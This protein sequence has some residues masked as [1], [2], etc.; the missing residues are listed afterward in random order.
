MWSQ[1]EWRGDERVPLLR[2]LG[3]HQVQDG[4]LKMNLHQGLNW[5]VLWGP[6]S[7]I[8]K[9]PA[10][11]TLPPPL[12]SPP[13]RGPLPSPP[14]RHTPHPG[15]RGWTESRPQPPTAVAPGLALHC[16]LRLPRPGRA[17]PPRPPAAASPADASRCPPAPA[18][19]APPTQERKAGGSNLGG[20]SRISHPTGT[21]LLHIANCFL[22]HFLA[23]GGVSRAPPGTGPALGPG[24][25]P[26]PPQ[27][28]RAPPSSPAS[29]PPTRPQFS[30]SL[31]SGFHQVRLF[32]TV[33][34]KDEP[35]I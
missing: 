22:S 16:S 26:P 30:V 4:L 19:P 20:P 24:A 10:T 1:K 9:V 25:S 34:S 15:P 18:S 21:S 8:S 13:L 12:R 5:A 14:L 29:A 17:Y 23:G 35:L 7:A 33:L 11:L 6:S 3:N 27:P 31:L 2:G 32:S 28:R